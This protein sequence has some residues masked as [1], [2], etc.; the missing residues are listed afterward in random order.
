MSKRNTEEAKKELL[1]KGTMDECIGV[2]LNSR[3]FS[4]KVKMDD[5]ERRRWAVYFV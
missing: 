2:M 4:K 3:E 1:G 5:E